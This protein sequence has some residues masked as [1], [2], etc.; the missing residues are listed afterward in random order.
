M[1]YTSLTSFSYRISIFCC[2]CPFSFLLFHFN[3]VFDVVL[4]MSRV[5]SFIVFSGF[6]WHPV[7]QH[8]HLN[9]LNTYKAAL[10]PGIF[11]LWKWHVGKR[12]DNF[13]AN[14]MALALALQL[15]MWFTTPRCEKIFLYEL[16]WHLLLFHTNLFFLRRF[17]FLLPHKRP[18][19]SI[20]CIRPTIPYPT[21]SF[22]MFT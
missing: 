18:N 6:E 8:P 16:N 4:A 3:G 2:C 1:K 14:D 15:P 19:E 7:H 17:F 20:R 11:L 12:A 9:D 13:Q 10:F 21:T 22:H 5:W